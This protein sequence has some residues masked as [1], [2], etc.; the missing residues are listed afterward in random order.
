[1]LGPVHITPE[2]FENAALFL[3]L[4]LPSTLIHHVFENAL[5]TGGIWKRRLCV[6]VWT[7][8]ILKT[9][10]LENDDVTM[11]TWFPWVSFPQ[12]QIQNDRWIFWFQIPPTLC[13]RKTYVA[14]SEWNLR[15]HISPSY[16]DVEYLKW[17]PISEPS[18]SVSPYVHDNVPNVP[19]PPAVNYRV[20]NW[21]KKHKTRLEKKKL[22]QS[23][24][25]TVD[26]NGSHTDEVNNK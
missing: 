24:T 15:C 9:E 7:E 17:W 16:S 18:N 3:L 4:G 8:N 11:I 21:T 25:C 5:Q 12:T 20:Q 22:F 26:F 13:G 1:M 14:F 2:K 23:S 10:L 6:L 19:H